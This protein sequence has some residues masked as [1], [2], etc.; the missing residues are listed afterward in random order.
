MLAGGPQAVAAEAAAGQA[1]RKVSY[2]PVTLPG[3]SALQLSWWFDHIADNDGAFFKP[4]SE[5]SKSIY[6][7]QSL[8]QAEGH[9][10]AVYVASRRVGGME[11]N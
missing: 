1:V 6:W 11:Q 7:E 9:I 5:N 10:G 3:V 2:G 4:L 8:Q